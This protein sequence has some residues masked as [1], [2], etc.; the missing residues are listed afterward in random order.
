VRDADVARERSCVCVCV[1]TSQHPYCYRNCF[2]APSVVC[3]LIYGGLRLTQRKKVKFMRLRC[4][5]N[6][7][8]I[9]LL[10]LPGLGLVVLL[11]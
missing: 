11:L 1:C 2:V 4:N 10:L 6:L 7:L 3:C 8:T 9:V 5:C